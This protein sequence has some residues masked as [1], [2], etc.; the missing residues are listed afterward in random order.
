MGRGSLYK[1]GNGKCYKQWSTKLEPLEVCVKDV[2]VV[3][4]EGIPGGRAWS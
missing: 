2:Q 1:L 4:L 3:K